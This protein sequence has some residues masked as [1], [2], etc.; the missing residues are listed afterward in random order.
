MKSSHFRI[1][2]PYTLVLR[3]K[4]GF[5]VIPTI[6]DGVSDEE[7]TFRQRVTELQIGVML[8]FD[9]RV[10]SYMKDDIIE[11]DLL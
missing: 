8:K 2:A 5:I 10:L 3:F 1:S 6:C 11:V 4:G 7:I 9:I